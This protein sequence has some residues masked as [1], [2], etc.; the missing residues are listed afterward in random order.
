M[1]RA[2]RPTPCSRPFGATTN[3]RVALVWDARY[4]LVLKALHGQ[5]FRAPAFVEQYSVNNPVTV[6]NPQLRLERIQ[7]SELVFSW[8]PWNKVQAD[9]T[10]YR[11]TMRDII[12][13]VTNPAPSTGKTFANAGKQHGRGLEL[14]AS[15]EVLHRPRLSG[16]FSLQKSTD[17]A[18]GQDAGLAPHRRRFGRA[19][20]L[21]APAWQLG[22]TFNHVAGRMRQTGGVRPRIADDSTADLSL[23]RDKALGS[24]SV[25]ATLLNLFNAD[26]REPSI[27]PGSIPFDIALPGRTLSVQLTHTW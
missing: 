7:T 15:W 26:A 22:A 5:A 10:L 23:R 18:S 27:A 16:N 25:R 12:A 20:W 8:Q 6:G 24:W 2:S 9:L 13:T 1:R 17:E 4:N 19:D 3:P 14:E 21:P 11:Y